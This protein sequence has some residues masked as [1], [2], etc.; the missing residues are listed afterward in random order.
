MQLIKFLPL[1]LLSSFCYA[2][3]YWNHL[4]E[5]YLN[6]TT[7]VPSFSA[8]TTSDLMTDKKAQEL[9]QQYD[10]LTRNYNLKQQYGILT[11]KDQSDYNDQMT[12]FGHTVFSAVQQKQIQEQSEKLNNSIN[13]NEV[14]S[15]ISKPV[16]AGA[17]LVAIYRGQPIKIKLSDESNIITTTNFPSQVAS[18]KLHSCDF[19]TSVEFNGNPSLPSD[20][21]PYSAVEKYKVSASKNIAL[22]ISGGVDYGVTST[23]LTSFVRRSVYKQIV[24]EFDYVDPTSE[25]AQSLRPPEKVIKLSY[26]VTF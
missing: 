13:S 9:T 10:D 1:L 4:N 23:Y 18:V 3:D 14:L 16:T 19:D 17:A 24:C 6:N 21:G 22:G 5:T 2:D 7:S 20:M 26:G 25:E 15:A 11:I 12:N 8:L